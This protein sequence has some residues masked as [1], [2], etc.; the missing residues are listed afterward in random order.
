MTMVRRRA[1]VHMRRGSRGKAGQ[2]RGYRRDR[3]SGADSNQVATDAASG[4]APIP[5]LRDRYIV[6]RWKRGERQWKSWVTSRDKLEPNLPTLDDLERDSAARPQ[7]E[8]T[9]GS[10]DG[11]RK[12]G[13]RCL[14]PA[15]SQE[16]RRVTGSGE[17]RLE[18]PEQL[19]HRR[20][21]IDRCDIKPLDREPRGDC[22]A[23]LT[24]ASRGT[25]GELDSSTE[26]WVMKVIHYG[27]FP[28]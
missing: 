22:A 24:R 12:H 26:P 16:K 17:L 7:Q 23:A 4:E 19:E 10:L 9:F 18:F 5:R 8:T 21:R 11:V 14:R 1:N 13:V 20:L 15:M 3:E 28:G 2:Y 6:A 27:A 25:G